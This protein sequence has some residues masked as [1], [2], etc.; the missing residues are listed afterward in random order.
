[1]LTISGW[2]VWG[3][4]GGA[5]FTALVVLAGIRMGY[6]KIKGG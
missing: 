1:M 3:T 6:R 2:L 4:I 5:I